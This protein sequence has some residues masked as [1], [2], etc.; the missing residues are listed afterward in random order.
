MLKI[1]YIKAFIFT[2][3][4]SLWCQESVPLIEASSAVDTSVITIGDRI[5]Y[6]VDINYQAGMRVEKPGAGVNL[7]QF[8]I[9]DYTIAEPVTESG[10]TY[11]KYEY[12]IS[13]FD[14]GSFTIPAFPVAYFPEDSA[15][16]YEIIEASA[17]DIYVESVL[18]PG[19][20][21]LKDI[22]PVIDLPV[23]LVFWISA[24]LIIMLVGVLLFFGYR[25]YKQRKEK[26]YLLKP[27]APP[28]PAHEVA[29]E[30]LEV[31]FAKDLIAL[32]NL[33]E[34]YIEISEIIRRYI[35][36]RYFVPALEETSGE[37]LAELNDQNLEKDAYQILKSFL[38]TSDLVKF[39]RYRPSDDEHKDVSSW[40]VNFVD[41]TKVIYTKPESDSNIESESQL[42]MEE[43][44]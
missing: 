21:E 13:V 15:G 17:I 4:L 10:R 35:E 8:E 7:G 25:L 16:P 19:E 43:S 36:N 12:I 34:F 39:A 37:T 3:A 33:K 32:G 20:A 9:K 42:L 11:L 40:A 28:R 23:D 18:Q 31:L 41:Q 44:T 29:M 5:I 27:P 1:I 38:H 22:K 6:T 2:L 30:A 26:G 24:I 14:T